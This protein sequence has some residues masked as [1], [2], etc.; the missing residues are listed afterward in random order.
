MRISRR[1]CDNQLNLKATA[2]FGVYALT[3]IYNAST[4]PGMND[5]VGYME[6]FRKKTREIMKV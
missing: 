6:K 3:S 1:C 5:L 4:C 2:W